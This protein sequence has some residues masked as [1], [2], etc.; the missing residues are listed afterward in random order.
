MGVVVDAELVRDG[1][2]QRVGR[3][4]GLVR[5]ELLDQHVGLGGVA[6]AE[7]GAG[8]LVDVADLVLLASVRPK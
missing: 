8:V 2:E 3:G 6:A 1:Q 4:D 7:D 5:R